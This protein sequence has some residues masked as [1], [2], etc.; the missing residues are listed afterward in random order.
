MIKENINFLCNLRFFI[1]I[2]AL[3]VLNIRDILLINVLF[4]SNQDEP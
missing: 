2:E 4:F 3:A 1:K